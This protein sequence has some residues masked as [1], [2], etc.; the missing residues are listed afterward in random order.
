MEDIDVM[1]EWWLPADPDALVHGRLTF[2][3]GDGGSLDLYGE[4]APG[5]GT[6]ARYPVVLGVAGGADYTLLD[7]FYTRRD[8]NWGGSTRYE[9]LAVNQVLHGSLLDD[10]GDLRGNSV[11]VALRH[12]TEWVTDSGIEEQ[13]TWAVD[14]AP[15]V[16]PVFSISTYRTPDQTAAAADGRTVVLSRHLG[17]KGDGVSS[18]TLTQAFSL[19]VTAA[20]PTRRLP[21]DDL[22][23]WA[24]DLQDLV[25]VATGRTATLQRVAFYDPDITRQALSGRYDR[26]P[27]EVIA[28]W[29]AGHDPDPARVERHRLLFSYDDLGG[30]DAV[31]RWLDTA[32]AHRGALGR[33]MATRYSTPMFVSDRLMNCCAALEAFDRKTTAK[34]TFRS[35]INRCVSLAGEPFSALVGDTAAWAAAVT[36]ARNE[37]A[38]HLEHPVRRASPATLYLS[39]SLYYLFVLCM[40]R[41]TGAPDTVYG[42]IIEHGQ[43]RWL[44]SAVRDASA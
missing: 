24:S 8:L 3:Q 20:D 11:T 4:L 35:R 16:E 5:S 33:V 21:L 30:I 25:S 38:H 15:P 19:R 10:P 12:L 13:H 6:S 2:S 31:A 43:Y 34:S 18:R 14:P 42:R 22:L 9:T 26:E 17:L 27:V 37:V 28:R 29:T 41:T 1:G 40:L 7:C 36:R 44:A 39:M 32:A 23:D